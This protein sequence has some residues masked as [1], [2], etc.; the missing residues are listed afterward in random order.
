[1]LE[2]IAIISPL[3]GYPND[4]VTTFYNKALESFAPEDIHVI[5][6][7]DQFEGTY[8]D[9]FFHY[10]L[11]NVLEYLEAN[12]L[13]KYDYVLF[14]DALDTTFL[15]QPTDLVEKFLELNCS[16]IFGAEQNLW[17]PTDF[18]H[19]Y[20][21]K[22][23]ISRYKY[24]NSGTYFGYVEK[25]I[26]HLKEIVEKRYIIDDQGTWTIQYLVHDDIII[27]QECNFFFSSLDSKDKV[28]VVDGN[29]IL[30]GVNAYIVHDNGPYTENTIKLV[31]MINNQK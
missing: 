10:K 11:E 19:L 16:I 27:D 14:L 3:Y 31:N 18:S 5:R 28:S 2:R 20:E 25:I 22:R 17:P 12:I 8:Y 1:M 7:H 23:V 13:G 24:L 9:K 6:S 30:D 4:Y 29:V 21:N 15:K 26:E